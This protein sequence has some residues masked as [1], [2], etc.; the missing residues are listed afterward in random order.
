MSINS[1]SSCF[2]ALK[3]K[4]HYQNSWRFRCVCINQDYFNCILLNM[5]KA[6]N[7]NNLI[8]NKTKKMF[9]KN[10]ITWKII[11][12]LFYR[13]KCYLKKITRKTKAIILCQ[14]FLWAA[15]VFLIALPNFHR[16]DTS[17]EKQLTGDRVNQLV[18]SDRWLYT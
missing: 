13:M 12:F 17:L 9:T 8:Y 4:R 6:K 1:P 10:T 11:Y 18:M 14:K 2:V 7:N 15:P 16:I 5:R 3:C